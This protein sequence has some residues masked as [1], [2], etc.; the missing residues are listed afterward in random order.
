MAAPVRVAILGAGIFAQDAYVPV[1]RELKNEL[2]PRFVWSR[3]QESS[4][5]LA[6][7]IREWAEDV[8]AV[9]GE[10]GLS[11]IESSAEV[12]CCSVVL[13]IQSQAALVKRMLAA[14]K[15]VL[16]EKPI[17]ASEEEAVEML[18]MY[19]SLAPHPSLS[20]KPFWGVAENFRLEPAFTKAA[21]LVRSLGELYT[22]SVCVEF[23]MPPTNK[24]YNSQWRRDPSLKGAFIFD[25][26]VHYIAGLRQMMQ[27]RIAS[28]SA[29]VS[30]MVP[31]LPPPDNLTATFTLEPAAGSSQTCS[32]TLQVTFCAPMNKMIWRAVCAQGVVKVERGSHEG[33]FGYKV[34][35]LKPGC[36][37]EMT[38][39]EFG[40]IDTELRTFA[41]HVAAVSGGR[42][43]PEDER[44]AQEENERLLSGA[45]AMEDLV[46]VA[47]CLK[48]G[49]LNGAPLQV[50]R[51]AF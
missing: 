16:Q 47:A 18:Q 51:T 1:L 21:E 22:A 4:E 45:E 32:G 17:A 40:G 44:P 48:S 2:L 11:R 34:T 42:H 23:S 38:F 10:D 6:A 25:C 12:P 8:E 31:G 39:V 37:Q 41:R 28:V 7:K 14:G 29:H 9:W 43:L 19:D 49:A 35:V 13:P 5:K 24:Y 33:K 46:T 36:P 27:R 20:A 30:H 15:H 26:A 50:E 3:S